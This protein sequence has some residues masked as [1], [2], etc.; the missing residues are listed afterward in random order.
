[1]R[2][3]SFLVALLWASAAG[4]AEWWW[5]GLNGQAPNR[6]VTY[7]DRESETRR[8]NAVIV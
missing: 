7:V 3:F 8:D 4:A 1:M 5:I 2:L 6:V